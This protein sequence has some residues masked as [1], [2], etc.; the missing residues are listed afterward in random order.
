[1]A[2]HYRSEY[3]WK[4][5]VVIGSEFGITTTECESIQR[6]PFITP[7][8][9]C[10][11]D[12]D[13]ALI[14]LTDDLATKR[15]ITNEIWQQYSKLFEE[16]EIIDVILVVSQYVFFSL[17]NNSLCVEVESALND[18]AGLSASAAVQS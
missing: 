1:M 5:H 17:V 14:E 18:I 7:A 9:S 2:V 16:S 13:A 11:S 8:P 6:V 10:F 3:V 15:T 12:R 4:H